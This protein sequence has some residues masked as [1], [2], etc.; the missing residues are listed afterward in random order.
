MQ[1]SQ[2]NQEKVLEAIRKGTVDAADLSF[3]NLIDEIVLKMKQLG[4]IAKLEE[5]FK[6]KRSTNKNIP[7][8]L[9]LTLA[10]IANTKIKNSLSDIPFALTDT[11]TLS[12]IG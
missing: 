4:L 11:K 12:E 7:Y 3:P 5:A 9:L 6:E 1:I 8:H 10:I 2:K